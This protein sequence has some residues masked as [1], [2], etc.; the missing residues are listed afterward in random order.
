MI[1]TEPVAARLTGD[2]RY[3]FPA[4]VWIVIGCAL[5]VWPFTIDNIPSQIVGA[6][7][8]M[9]CLAFVRIREAM[10]ADLFAAPWVLYGLLLL[11][12]GAHFAFTEQ[13]TGL[14]LF[15]VYIIKIPILYVLVLAARDTLIRTGFARE[16]AHRVIW[17]A[18]LV[19]LAVVVLQLIFP[20]F[21]H[22]SLVHLG[23]FRATDVINRNAQGHAFRFL[24][25]NGFLFSSHG[26]AFAL[27]AL[28]LRAF[29]TTDGAT[30]FTGLLFAIEIACLIM[31]LISGRSALPLVVLYLGVSLYLADSWLRRL[32]LLAFFIPLPIVATLVLQQ[33]PEGRN[34]LHWMVEPA[35]TSLSRGTVGSLSV[36]ET[37]ESF[38][39]VAS[40]RSTAPAPRGHPA[41]AMEPVPSV[42]PEP[43]VQTAPGRATQ[44]LAEEKT[45]IS[46]AENPWI[47]QGIYFRHN[48]DY[49]A[50]GMIP[51]DAGFVRLIQVSGYIGLALFILFWLTFGLRA[52][53]TT[54]SWREPQRLYLVLFVGYGM[55]FFLKSE[56]LYQNFFVFY[57]FSIYQYLN[58]RPATS[59]AHHV[60]KSLSAAP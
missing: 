37:L 52:W 20:S 54:G 7:M 1:Q 15:T 40:T 39:G 36:D 57:F 22:W 16:G 48:V 6:V 21:H 5:I 12:L 25:V 17:L 35:Q 32:A 51:S 38:R 27:T 44:A 50:I 13:H 2:H 58:R 18:V 30:R 43:P 26:V 23:G 56:W 34:L 41:D 28:G 14:L 59:H 45:K 42:L 10:R 19:P 8:L 60:R 9:P 49:V 47:G 24:G 31:A 4:A 53:F 11:G 33:T 29:R 3:Q 55:L 46:Q